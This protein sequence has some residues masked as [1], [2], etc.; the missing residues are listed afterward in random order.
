M[1]RCGHAAPSACGPADKVTGAVRSAIQASRA[2][3]PS[4]E[5][6]VLSETV[7]I[8][9]VGFQQR[10]GAVTR[11][12]SVERNRFNQNDIRFLFTFLDCHF[13]LG[14]AHGRLRKSRQDRRQREDVVAALVKVADACFRFS[15]I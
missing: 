6:I 4:V 14:T 2:L 8:L 9:P 10:R 15:S 12:A 13:A 1:A 7:I 5:I 11:D 3:S